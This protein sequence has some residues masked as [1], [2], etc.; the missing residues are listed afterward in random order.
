MLMKLVVLQSAAGSVGRR[1]GRRYE[2]GNS[3][4]SDAV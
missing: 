2:T 4:R 1:D 3:V